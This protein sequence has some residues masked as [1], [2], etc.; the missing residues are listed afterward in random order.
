MNWPWC[1]NLCIISLSSVCRG[2]RIETKEISKES[3][4]TRCLIPYGNALSFRI[5]LSLHIDTRHSFA[6]FAFRFFSFFPLARARWYS[7][8]RKEKIFQKINSTNVSRDWVKR[9]R[10]SLTRLRFVSFAHFCFAVFEYCEIFAFSCSTV[11]RNISI[12][13]K[14]RKE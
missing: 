1:M 3:Y 2:R 7:K 10:N 12:K 9:R 11:T 5:E 8:K 4:L 13:K 6:T 14:K